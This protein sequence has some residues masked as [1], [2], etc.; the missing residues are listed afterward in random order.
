[1][2][3]E[4][5]S[6]PPGHNLPILLYHT[7]H[8]LATKKKKYQLIFCIIPIDFFQIMQYIENG[9]VQLDNLI[10]TSRVQIRRPEAPADDQSRL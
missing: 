2:P 4:L 1:M 7:L 10:N 5:V 3:P 8:T 9:I 6:A